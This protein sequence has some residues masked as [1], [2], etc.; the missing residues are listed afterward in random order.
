MKVKYSVTFEFETQ[1]PVTHTGTVAGSTTPTV[2]KRAVKEAMDAHPGLSWSSFVCV[3]LERLP[4]E[5][6]AA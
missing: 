1:P 4:E 3:L 5:K 2:V 6:A